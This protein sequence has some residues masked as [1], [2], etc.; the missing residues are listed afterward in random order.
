MDLGRAGPT[1]PSD[2]RYRASR[3]RLNGVCAAVR[4]DSNP[5]ARRTSASR[6]G[7]ACVPSAARP[8]WLSEPGVQSSVEK[9]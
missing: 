5:P 2:A 4:T 3:M 6:A 8:G 1:V 7:P 9:P